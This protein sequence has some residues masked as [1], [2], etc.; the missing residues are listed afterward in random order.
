MKKSLF[1]FLLLITNCSFLI[2]QSGW[3]QVTSP[4]NNL[5]LNRIQF[6]SP[7]TGYAIGPIATSYY[8][9]LL[10]TVNGGTNWQSIPLDSMWYWSLY[11]VDN[12][13]GFTVGE[14]IITHHGI[15]KKTTN[16]GINWVTCLVGLS[17]DYFSVY[18]IDYNTGFA[19]GKYDVVVKTT[20]G[21]MNWVS[22]PGAIC[23]VTFNDVYFF[24]ANTGFV[25]G[26]KINKTTN[27][28]DNWYICNLFNEEYMSIFFV[29]YTTGYINAYSGNIYKTTDS[30]E[31]WFYIS[32]INQ[33][34]NSIFFT[35]L[36][37]G[38]TCPGGHDVHK[39]TN[40][41]LN[42]FQQNTGPSNYYYSV[43]FL[44]EN[45]GFV[46]GDDGVILKTTNGGNVFI[47]N[48]T[49][50]IPDKFSIYQNYPNPFNPTT[51][52]KF[53]IAS[54]VK[55]KTSDV[56]LIIYDI[57][58]REIQTLVNESLHPGTYEV[59]FEGSKLAS[60]VYFYQLRSGDFINTKK[61]IILK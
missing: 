40:G 19:G 45:T 36:N 27:G 8:G 6:T 16:G 58:G 28:G 7:D 23:G 53:D 49:N 24:N 11:F 3:F 26:S 33:G 38:Y 59:T 47:H 61:L 55:R 10:K 4:I 9:Y 2:A 48:I 44:N 43:F 15:I 41:G 29:N 54:D 30:G 5:I 20:N 21:G 12:N 50:E 46:A 35:S 37:T 34:L 56:K 31:N 42:W 25:I 17:N 13:T 60:G 1:V 52:I 39:T 57:T 51:K 32:T 22:K 18:F 14:D